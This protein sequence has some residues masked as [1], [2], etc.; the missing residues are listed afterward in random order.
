MQRLDAG[1]DLLEQS[2]ATVPPRRF[3]RAGPRVARRP[4]APTSGVEGDVQDFNAAVRH[5]ALGSMHRG[6]EEYEEEKL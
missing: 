6:L 4:R 1:G 3:D 2:G 5:P